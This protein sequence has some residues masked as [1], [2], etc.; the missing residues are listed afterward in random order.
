MYKD[1]WHKRDIIKMN[2]D[3]RP[4]GERCDSVTK[5]PI[6]NFY[7]NI[8]PTSLMRTASMK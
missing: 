2:S 8:F 6:A 1:A 7:I 3:N 4:R 5:R